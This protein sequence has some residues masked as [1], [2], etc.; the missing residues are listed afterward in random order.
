[1]RDGHPVP[2]LCTRL[3]LGLLGLTALSL[4]LCACEPTRDMPVLTCS[5]DSDCPATGRL[6]CNTKT[7]RCEVCDGCSS[8]V[9]AA[10][11]VSP[12][13]E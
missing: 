12:A 11:D 5:V 7:K 13:A 4:A 1:M 3:R 9:D 10:A 6:T 8:A 2:S